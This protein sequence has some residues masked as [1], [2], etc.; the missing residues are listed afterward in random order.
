MRKHAVVA[1]GLIFPAFAMWALF[2]I[3]PVGV[4]GY[5]SLFKTNFINTTFVGLANYARLLRDPAFGETLGNSFLYVAFIPTTSLILA[6]GLALAVYNDSKRMQSYLR[7]MIYVPTVVAGVILTMVWRWVFHPVSGLANWLLSMVGIESVIWMGGRLSAIIG[8]SV[9]IL[10]FSCGGQLVIIMASMLSIPHEI[11][12]AARIDGASWLQVKMRIVL[13]L[14]VPIIMLCLLVAVIG[15]MQIWETIF[16]MSPTQDAH[17][18]M[19]SIYFTGF[20]MGRY[21]LASA[22]TIVLMVIIACVAGVQRVIER[23]T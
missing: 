11:V 4:V 10:S 1:Y 20:Q 5:L 16:L 13:P 6:I 12:E 14:L 22:M 2:F 19:Y 17:N 7:A 21:G 9:V 3:L 23:F 18:L 15:A 8:I